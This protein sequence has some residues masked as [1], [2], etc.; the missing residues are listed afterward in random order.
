MLPFLKRK[1]ICSSNV[2]SEKCEKYCVEV[3][4]TFTISVYCCLCANRWYLVMKADT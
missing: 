3:L 4:E 2:K 1:Q